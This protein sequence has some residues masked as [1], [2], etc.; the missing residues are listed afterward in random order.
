VLRPVMAQELDA[1]LAQPLQ[2]RFSGKFFT[3][4]PSASLAAAAGRSG[5]DAARM[6]ENGGAAEPSAAAQGMPQTIKLA[7]RLADSNTAARVSLSPVLRFG[8][9]LNVRILDTIIMSLGL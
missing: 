6:S 5:R 9:L 2:A 8:T 3:G 4:V 7:Q 1:L